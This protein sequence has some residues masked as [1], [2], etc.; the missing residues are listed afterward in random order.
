MTALDHTAATR[1]QSSQLTNIS[2]NKA[3]CTNKR[4]EHPFTGTCRHCEKEGHRV[5]ECPDKPPKTCRICGKEGHKAITCEELRTD[6]FKD[7]QEMPADEAWAKMKEADAAKDLDDF[8]D[9]GCSS[10][11]TRRLSYADYP[12]KGFLLICQSSFRQAR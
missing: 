1:S 7:A 11:S 6:V 4:I 9:V 3:G 10:L 2:H 5:A 8:K 12:P